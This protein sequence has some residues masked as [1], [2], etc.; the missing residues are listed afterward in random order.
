[1][2]W[3]G[4]TVISFVNALMMVVMIMNELVWPMMIM[5]VWWVGVMI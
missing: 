4:L 3:H 5:V 2:E 1:M